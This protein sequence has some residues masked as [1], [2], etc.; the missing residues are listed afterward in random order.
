MLNNIQPLPETPQ[1]VSDPVMYQK[2]LEI[3][4]T[5]SAILAYFRDI[6]EAVDDVDAAAKGIAIGEWYISAGTL[7]VR[8]T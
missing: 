6:K 2:L 4:L 7:V 3:H 8:K 5:L 1:D